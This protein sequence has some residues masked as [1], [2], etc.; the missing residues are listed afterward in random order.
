[1]HRNQKWL[2]F[3]YAL[4]KNG[5]LNEENRNCNQLILLVPGAGLEPARWS[6]SEGF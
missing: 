6:P 2:H 1:M 3:S 5:L 4:Q